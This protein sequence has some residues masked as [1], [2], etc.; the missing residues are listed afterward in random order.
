MMQWYNEANLL[1]KSD[2]RQGPIAQLDSP[3]N[4]V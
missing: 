1:I 4:K 2:S 3:I